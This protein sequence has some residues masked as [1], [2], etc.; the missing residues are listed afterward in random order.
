VREPELNAAGEGRQ[1]SAVYLSLL[2]LGPYLVVL[3]PEDV[4]GGERARA[5]PTGEL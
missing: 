2:S 5:D 1:G 4:G 3:L